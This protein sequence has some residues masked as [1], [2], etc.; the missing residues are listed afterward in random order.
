MR[1]AVQ[2]RYNEITELSKCISPALL[3]YVAGGVLCGNGHHEQQHDPE[4][5]ALLIEKQ[6]SIFEEL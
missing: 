3:H 2:T 5:L 6:T 4:K 1:K